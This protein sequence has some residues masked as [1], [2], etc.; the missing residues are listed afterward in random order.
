[1]IGGWGVRGLF[2][3]PPV[4]YKPRIVWKKGSWYCDDIAYGPTPSIAYEAWKLFK[5]AGYLMTP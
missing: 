3:K 2:R 1:M 5:D 4:A